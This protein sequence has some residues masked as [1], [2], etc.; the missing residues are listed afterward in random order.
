VPAVLIAVHTIY[1]ELVVSSPA[2]AETIDVCTAQLRLY[3]QTVFDSRFGDEVEQTVV[4]TARLRIF[5]GIV[6][7]ALAFAQ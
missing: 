1:A 4:Q 3:L 6:N 5:R 7:C 2:V